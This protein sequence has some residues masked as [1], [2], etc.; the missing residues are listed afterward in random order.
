MYISGMY[1]QVRFREK[2]YFGLWG[3]KEGCA[4]ELEILKNEGN[5]GK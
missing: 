1:S 3:L 5:Y 4:C 2:V